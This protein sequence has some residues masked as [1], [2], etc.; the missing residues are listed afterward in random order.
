MGFAKTAQNA[1][2]V[3][4]GLLHQNAGTPGSSFESCTGSPRAVFVMVAQQ[5]S[6]EGIAETFQFKDLPIVEQ[7]GFRFSNACNSLMQA[8]G[9]PDNNG[10]V[11]LH[12]FILSQT[13]V[14]HASI[15]CCVVVSS[16]CSAS[17]W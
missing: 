1:Q 3:S 6:F 2:F 12:V 17:L 11:P 15:S 9:F 13:R 4:V 5:A 14:H 10:I 8:L 16:S 7:H